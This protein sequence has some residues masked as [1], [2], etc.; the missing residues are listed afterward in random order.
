MKP[1]TFSV[2]Y[3]L[4]DPDHGPMLDD[5]WPTTLRV[6]VRPGTQGTQPRCMPQPHPYLLPEAQTR[7]GSPEGILPLP[8]PTNPQHAPAGLPVACAEPS[9]EGKD[10]AFSYWR[11]PGPQH[12]VS[13]EWVTG[14]EGPQSLLP[15]RL[16]M[17]PW[18]P[19]GPALWL[20]E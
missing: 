12:R 20:V 9:F 5:G 17:R 15:P 7:G 2:E 10:Q 19:R 4:E 14:S 3:S 18:R 1:V 8:L 6:S 13:V 16:Q 11:R